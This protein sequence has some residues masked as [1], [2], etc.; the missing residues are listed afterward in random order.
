MHDVSTALTRQPIELVRSASPGDWS[1]RP[2]VL[3]V[4]WRVSRTLREKTYLP[5]TT[6]VVGS[7]SGR[8]LSSSKS[9]SFSTSSSILG[10]STLGGGEGAAAA[11]APAAA[12]AAAAAATEVPMVAELPA[13]AS[14]GGGG[15]R[16]RFG[17]GRPHRN[18]TTS[19]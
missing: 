7:K 18:L 16:R 4:G 9:S 6:S 15:G 5:S 13:E 19:S 11:E 2:K 17:Y 10:G 14:I 12:A 1:S 3:R 8:T